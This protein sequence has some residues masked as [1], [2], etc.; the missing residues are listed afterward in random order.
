M[1]GVRNIEGD[2]II[3]IYILLNGAQLFFKTFVFIFHFLFISL[4]FVSW[5]F[6]WKY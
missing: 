4:H 6:K 5:L 3:I 2:P 1:N